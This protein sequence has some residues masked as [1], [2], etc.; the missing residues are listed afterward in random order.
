MRKSQATTIDEK[1]SPRRSLRHV[2]AVSLG[3]LIAPL[4]YEGTN[5]CIAN[6]QMMTGQQIVVETPVYDAICESLDATRLWFNQMTG[7]FFRDPAWKPGTTIGLAL[8]WAAGAAM[9]LR[10]A[11]TR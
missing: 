4:V 1:P 8:A 3:L 10:A 6:W 7:G 9:L 5:V 2:V 11:R